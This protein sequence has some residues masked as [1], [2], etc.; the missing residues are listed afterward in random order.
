MGHSRKVEEDRDRKLTDGRNNQKCAKCGDRLMWLFHAR[1]R[2]YQGIPAGFALCDNC[3]KE[4]GF[5]DDCGLPLTATAGRIVGE[6]DR[7]VCRVC[8]DRRY[9]QCPRCRSWYHNEEYD[10]EPN[11][12]PPKRKDC[13]GCRAIDR[14]DHDY[15]ENLGRYCREFCSRYDTGAS[16]RLCSCFEVRDGGVY[17]DDYWLRNGDAARKE[18]ARVQISWR[19]DGVLDPA[20]YGDNDGCPYY[21]RVEKDGNGEDYYAEQYEKACTLVLWGKLGVGE[22]PDECANCPERPTGPSSLYLN[23]QQTGQKGDPNVCV[24]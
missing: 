17:A 15:Y 3:K 11:E 16:C 18:E 21:E 9:R 2:G 6:D 24:H 22:M 12:T 1:S 14:F 5:C 8:R 7:F 19:Y 23:G 13:R 4:Q 20:E 10:P